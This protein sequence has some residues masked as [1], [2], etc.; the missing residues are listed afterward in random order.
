MNECAGSVMLKPENLLTKN[1]AILRFSQ[2]N[3]FKLRSSYICDDIILNYRKSD[4]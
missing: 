1:F 2:Y 4:K 3:V